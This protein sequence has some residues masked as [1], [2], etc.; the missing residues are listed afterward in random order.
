MITIDQFSSDIDNEFLKIKSNLQ[1]HIKSGHDVQSKKTF[2]SSHVPQEVIVSAELLLDTVVNAL[3]DE[4][5]SLLKGANVELQNKFYDHGFRERV[6]DWTVQIENKLSL[7]P[8]YVKYSTDPQM[9]HG[10]IAAGVSLIAGAT[11][12]GVVFIPNMMIGAI[13]SGIITLVLSAAAFKFAHD[14]AESKAID[15]MVEDI[16]KFL[17]SSKIQVRDW[18]DKVIKAF[19]S[20]FSSFCRSNG[21]EVL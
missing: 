14:K 6:K 3:M 16:D 4:S 13:V 2:L 1:I 9:V 17:D 10:L 5:R 20:E 15:R 8:E 21:W 7:E 11:I 19:A 12:T 18:L